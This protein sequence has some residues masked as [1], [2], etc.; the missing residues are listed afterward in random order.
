MKIIN[1]IEQ[2]ETIT[3]K[4]SEYSPSKKLRGEK[5]KKKLKIL[6]VGSIKS[7]FA[8]KPITG[9][10]DPILMISINAEIRLIKKKK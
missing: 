1:V 2:T 3:L 6:D 9:R 8:T 4:L 5:F 7:S 10:I